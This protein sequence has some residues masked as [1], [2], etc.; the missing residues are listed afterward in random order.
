MSI[1]VIDIQPDPKTRMI[2][3]R[4]TV[5]VHTGRSK[6]VR[7]LDLG[8]PEGADLIRNV[9]REVDERIREVLK[10]DGSS[11]AEGEER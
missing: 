7:I 5:V 4:V 1:S 8:I 11:L 2:R 6:F 3:H 9:K 10:K